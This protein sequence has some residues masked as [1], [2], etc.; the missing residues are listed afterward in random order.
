[1]HEH[2]LTCLKVLAYYVPDEILIVELQFYNIVEDQNVTLPWT[3]SETEIQRTNLIFTRFQIFKC[4]SVW[5][6]KVQIAFFSNHSIKLFKSHKIDMHWFLPVLTSLQIIS[7]VF[8][9]LTLQSVFFS[10]RISIG[11]H[12]LC[13]L[14]IQKITSYLFRQYNY[15]IMIWQKC[16]KLDCILF[17]HTWANFH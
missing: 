17:S 7:K 13:H 1:M 16:P 9:K 11:N 10:Y 3:P 2:D 6:Q 14:Y 5:K 15:F 12:C 4:E 8:L